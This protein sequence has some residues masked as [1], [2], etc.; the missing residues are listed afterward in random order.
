MYFAFL[1]SSHSMTSGAI[2]Y[3]DP[4]NELRLVPSG[5]AI[6]HDAKSVSFT[7]SVKKCVKMMKAYVSLKKVMG[8]DRC[9]L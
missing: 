8:D 4:R 5:L 6:E 9:F 1:F 7:L 3:G 2:Q